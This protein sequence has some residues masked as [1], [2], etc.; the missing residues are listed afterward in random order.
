MLDDDAPDDAG[1]ISAGLDERAAV[2]VVRPSA[3]DAGR[4]PDE[5]SARSMLT[6]E[7][8]KKRAQLD[9]QRRTRAMLLEGTLASDP[10]DGHRAV[11]E[12]VR[13]AFRAAAQEVVHELELPHQLEL[14]PETQVRDDGRRNDA[15]AAPIPP[16]PGIA[17]LDLDFAWPCDDGIRGDERPVRARG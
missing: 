14:V 9:A 3:R 7:R 11:L 12:P 17:E 15:G 5:L 4:D 1:L 8:R 13:P 16:E 10:L 6:A 2:Q